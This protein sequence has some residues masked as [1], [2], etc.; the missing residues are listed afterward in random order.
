M[1]ALF[2][3]D[4]MNKKQ[5]Q[6]EIRQRAQSLYQE[7]L[8]AE[9]TFIDTV[10]E[11]DAKRKSGLEVISQ[12]HLQ[13]ME[14]IKKDYEIDYKEITEES[15]NLML[16]LNISDLPWSDE[17]WNNYDPGSI[18]HIPH[19]IRIGK[20][21]H[22]SKYNSFETPAIMPIIGYGK[23]ILIEAKGK[24]KD[25]ARTAI[26]S[27]TLRLL[28]L[29]PPG[30][31][32]LICIDPVGLGE[33][34][35]GFIQ[36]LPDTITQGK[37]WTEPNHI[38]QQL[39]NLEQDMATI[40]QKYLGKRY[41]N[42]EE[43]NKDAGMV[44]EP[45]RLLV[46]SDFPARFSDFAAQRLI[47][48]ATNGPL[49]GVYVL[50]MVD[51]ETKLPYNFNLEDL[52]RTS[53]L[54]TCDS[55]FA[56]WKEDKLENCALIFDNPPAKEKFIQLVQKI[57]EATRFL[58]KVEVPFQ[59][60]V[61]DQSHWWTGD[62][63]NEVRF[64]IGQLGAKKFQIMSINGDQEHDALIIGKVGYGKSNLLQVI[65]DSLITR[66]S[67][68][69]ISLYLLDLKQ[70]T[71]EVYAINR[72][73]H[74]KV[75]AIRAE[76]EFA[77]SV[78][79]RVEQELRHRKD[80]FTSIGELDLAGFRGSSSQSLPR[81]FLFIDEFQDL[82]YED[83]VARIAENILEN[84]VRVGRS[85]GIHVILA[86]QT[87]RGQHALPNVI[88]DLI[89]IRIAL[90]CA[91]ADARL[92]LSDDN[93]E[94]FLLERPGEAIYNDLNGRVEGNSRFQT[95]W[96]DKNERETLIKNVHSYAKEKGVHQ[97]PDQIIFD[98]REGVDLNTNP[99]LRELLK[100]YP[101]IKNIG[102]HLAW[103]GGPIEIKP[104]TNIK[105]RRS[106]GKNLII[107]GVD[108]TGSTIIA[109]TSSI[110]ISLATQYPKD[111]AKYFIINFNESEQS[112][113]HIANLIKTFNINAQILNTQ[114]EA[115]KIIVDLLKEL[116]ERESGENSKTF[117][118]HYLIIL[119]AQNFRRLRNDTIAEDGQETL[120]SSLLIICSRGPEFGIFSIIQCD[121][122][123]NFERGLGRSGLDEFD[124]RVG[125]QMSA[126][127]SRALFE[128]EKACE[129]G[130][131][132]GLF[133]DI[134]EQNTP[135]KFRPYT[136][137]DLD[138]LCKSMMNH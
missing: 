132:R 81:I 95:F 4:K 131:N 16:S 125:L 52:E 76:M 19:T 137:P 31:L 61:D 66:Y 106:A 64:P 24:G 82:F 47:S 23:N 33:T 74:A 94:A 17:A 119:G 87:L 124:L 59:G 71:F 126:D 18:I 9:K 103:I 67:P 98:G 29:I 12:Q 80:L 58:A 99:N 92:I 46:I 14:K 90:Q 43:Y 32:R 69:E 49:V 134:N 79:K 113:D 8:K 28:T 11:A 51:I 37:S 34:V 88:K 65:I 138:F 77:L 35:A 122:L 96:L 1:P 120:S 13:A 3:F 5:L 60:E 93:S 62:A 73:P 128:N 68:Q 114:R 110:M 118:D 115:E 40:K 111:N 2:G 30:K 20:L 102:T 54:I 15:N 133:L 25:I 97:D 50:A 75:V 136:L 104:H 39:A 123:R 26:Q 91:D 117:P 130:P 36:D 56:K 57:S 86:S 41:S 27:I 53:H 6:Q 121:N 116:I 84:L 45:Y 105:F 135:E 48:I 100:N 127:D 109:L 85:F 108:T 10:E 112:N 89:P 55:S 21:S 107:S 44:E 42:I 70:V 78:L 63:S 38:E 101:P 22:L 83:Q 7:Y 72:I 129:L